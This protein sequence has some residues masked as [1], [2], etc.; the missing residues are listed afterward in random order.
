MLKIKGEKDEIGPAARKNVINN[1]N[2]ECTEITEKRS[3]SLP[4]F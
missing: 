3:H 2:E 1:R 4:I